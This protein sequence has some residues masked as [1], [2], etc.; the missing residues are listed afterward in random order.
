MIK[1]LFVCAGNICRSPMAEGVFQDMVAKAG[2]QAHITAD[3]AG[4]GRWHIG[5]QAHP[6]T[7]SLLEQ[8]GIRYEGRARQFT[9][10]DLETFDYVLAM[11]ADNLSD[12]LSKARGTHDSKVRLFLSD[13]NAAGTTDVREVPDPYYTGVYEQVY[14]LVTAGGEALLATLRREHNL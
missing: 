11:D 3:S 1:V 2:L 6:N 10:Q 12:I 13:A 5:E 4:T 14:A 7:R 9:T 8:H